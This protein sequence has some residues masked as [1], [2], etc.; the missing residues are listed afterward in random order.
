MSA[1]KWLTIEEQDKVYAKI[2]QT[3][4]P[5]FQFMRSYGCRINEALGLLK[6]NVFLDHNPPY[7]VLA[8]VLGTKGNLKPTTKTKR[9]RILPIIPE[10]RWIFLNSED[11]KLV[12]T[13]NGKPYSNKILNRVWKKATT[14]AGVKINLYNGVR[15]SFGCQRLNSGYGLDTIKA[16]MGHTSTK[17]TERYAA[18]ELKSLENIIRGKSIYNIFIPESGVK[19][20]ENK[21]KKWMDSKV[22]DL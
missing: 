20:L 4:L 16:I 13:K 11:P 22:I 5:I 9:A 21:G 2:S 1:V 8:T 12:F 14:E 15:H 7:V 10:I 6:E 18:Y 17:T 3:D 19:L